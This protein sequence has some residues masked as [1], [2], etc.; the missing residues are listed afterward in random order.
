[1][2]EPEK[3]TIVVLK[4]A[5]KHGFSEEELKAAWRKPMAMR[6]RNFDVPCFIAAAGADSRGQLVE[7]LGAEQ[8]DGAVIIYHAMK[9]TKKMAG[10]LG[11]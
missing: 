4:C 7:M 2:L 1:M 11:L 5:M 8:D 6:Y 3:A 9:L 10:E